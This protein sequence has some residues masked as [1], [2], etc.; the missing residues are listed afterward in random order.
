[1][2]KANAY[3]FGGIFLIAAMVRETF[4]ELINND[5]YDGFIFG[6]IFVVIGILWIKE[7][8][9]KRKDLNKEE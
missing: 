6:S 3:I 2:F 9:K 8:I 5:S 7:G 4:V 1:M